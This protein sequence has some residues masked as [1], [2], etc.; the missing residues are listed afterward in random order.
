KAI[1]HIK[2]LLTLNEKKSKLAQFEYQTRSFLQRVK[3]KISK[4]F[5]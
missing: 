2:S 5:K 4:S 3:Y 1:R